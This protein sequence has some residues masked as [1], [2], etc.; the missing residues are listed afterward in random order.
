LD[1]VASQLRFDAGVVIVQAVAVEEAFPW[2][3]F[4]L[5]L[6]FFH[7]V[8]HLADWTGRN[9]SDDI[10]GGYIRKNDRTRGYDRI[11]SDRYI[12]QHDR[13]VADEDIV[14]EIDFTDRIQ[15]DAVSE[16]KHAGRAVVADDGAVGEVNV[17]ADPHKG[18]I[19]DV[20]G[21]KDA[22]V[23]TN[24]VK[25][26]VQPKKLCVLARRVYKA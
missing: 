10:S 16:A 15:P 23:F 7:Q 8:G 5:H 12:G 14:A 4:R 2:E 20:G 17:I 13:P 26:A 24:R 18:G 11:G 19:G 25:S 3:G 1:P 21:G 22:A 9:A 6:Q